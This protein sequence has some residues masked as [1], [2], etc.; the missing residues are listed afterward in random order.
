MAYHK[1]V[2]DWGWYYGA[3]V[4]LDDVNSVISQQKDKLKKDLI[5]DLFLIAVTL[6]LAII[7]IFR[8]AQKHS[9]NLKSDLEKL[10]SFFKNLSIKSEPMNTDSL[11]FSELQQLSDSAN[12]MLENQKK[13]AQE[14]GRYEQQLQQSQ[15]MDV[16]SQVVGGVAHDFNNL[17]GVIL[18]FGE[19][20]E[21]KLTNDP[22]LEGY[23]RQINIAGARGAKLTRKLLSL[24]RQQT[25]EAQNCN[26]NDLLNEEKSFLHKSLT[27]KINLKYDL[28]DEIWP[29][30]IDRSDF[31]D[32][33]LN[34]CVNAMHAMK[35]SQQDSRILIKT[36]NVVI[37]EYKP[38]NANLKHG[39]Y[40]KI[41]ITDN[42]IGMTQETKEK[43][44]EPFFTTR[45][46]GTGLG[47]SQV[48]SFA[49]RSGG[50]VLVDSTV[51]EG[52]TFTILFPR[53]IDTIKEKIPGTSTSQGNS[54]LNG[55]EVIL[56]VDDEPALRKLSA[57]ILSQH[58]YTVLQAEDG[59]DALGVLESAQ[60]NLVLSDVIMPNMDGNLLAEKIKRIYP[61]IKIQLLSGYSQDDQIS[62][63]N[64]DLFDNIL[65]KPIDSKT[66]LS[67]I[68]ELLDS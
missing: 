21:S 33:I 18:G 43:I 26:V 57:N 17:L 1:T 32:V 50:T 19:I 60:V 31:E 68:R 59:I 51:G 28:R 14:K 58:G 53:Y 44:F 54:N 22:K 38:N 15:K 46:T 64:K 35:E 45:E 6:L 9:V 62:E 34:I 29:V 7:V 12:I 10:L 8:L 56:V 3:G 52:T 55:S 27:S 25:S 41:T 16:V 65:K 66:L 63:V 49:K 2:Q 23:C 37:D 40:V 20:L 42:G 61:D 48:Y 5:F 11:I 4:Y 30:W 39:D 13:A 47:L 24:T 67:R 36:N